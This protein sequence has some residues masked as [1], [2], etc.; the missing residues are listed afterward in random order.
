MP[1]GMEYF[2]ATSQQQLEYIKR[3]IDRCDYYIILVAGRYGSI[4]PSGY[5]FTEEEYRY[6]ISK[7]MPV[8]AFLHE[9]IG[10][11][12]LSKVEND[13]CIRKKLEE[14]R[15]ELCK[16]RIV[17]FWKVGGDLP[18]KVTVALMNAINLTPAVGWIRGDQ[19]I[20]P[21]VYEER[22]RL[23]RK[24]I[25]LEADDRPLEF[26]FPNNLE[27]INKTIQFEAT[28]NFL[29]EKIGNSKSK[30]LRTLNFEFGITWKEIFQCI[31]EILKAPTSEY[32]ISKALEKY[33]KKLHKEKN[34][35]ESEE[36][37]IEIKNINVKDIANQLTSYDLITSEGYRS[38][39][40]LMKVF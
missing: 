3:V 9:N 16:D 8:L 12:A 39:A 10:D 4:S 37:S 38:T 32:V 7:G 29:E 19:A 34:K 23:R 5:S 40:G 18:A 21:K 35:E 20:D 17:D 31:S 24:I 14:F 1:A 13:P 33:A 25:E 30:V 2:P 27:S 28:V 36:I 11:I 22:D 6:A 15:D 26:N